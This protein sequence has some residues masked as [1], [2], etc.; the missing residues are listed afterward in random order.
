MRLLLEADH[1]NRHFL[2]GETAFFGHLAG[3]EHHIALCFGTACQD[4]ALRLLFS[5][6]GLGLV[7][8]VNHG[9]RNLLAL[10]RTTSAVFAAIGQANALANAC[11]QQSFAAVSTE[12][13]ATW[14]NGDLEAHV[15]VILG[16][17]EIL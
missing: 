4:Q 15:F 7:F 16:G 10:A 13:T 14:L 17:S 1:T 12:S 6:Q 8:A 5:T 11:R 9:A 2:D 3:L